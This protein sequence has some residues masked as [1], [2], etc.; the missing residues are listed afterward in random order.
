MRDGPFALERLVGQGGMGEVY[1]ATERATG[2]PVAVKLLR[3]VEPGHLGRFHR[4]AD[5]LMAIEHPAVVEYV[6]HG[7]AE[8]GRPYLAMEW[9][10]GETL[11]QRLERGA[12]SATETVA[13][14]IRVAEGLVAAHARG[15]VHCDLKPSNLLLANGRLEEAKILD[16]GIARRVW[17]QRD[18][19]A[20]SVPG[21]IAGTPAYM[22]P[23][24]ARGEPK[25]RPSTDTFALGAVLY[26]C[27]TGTRA[28]GGENALAT[29]AEICF[30][31]PPPPRSLRPEVPPDLERLVLRM[32]FK[33]ETARPKDAIEVGREL[34]RIELSPG[35]ATAPPPAI[36]RKERRASTLVL[37]A[38]LDVPADDPDE[39]QSETHERATNRQRVLLTSLL[40]PY[41]GRLE[42]LAGGVL[43]VYFSE[44][45]APTDLATRAARFALAVG[46]ALM[47]A[48]VVVCTGRVTL[49]DRPS[50]G[51]LVDG[52]LPL[53]T[54]KGPGIR[55]DAATAELLRARFVVDGDS[56]SRGAVLSAER[57]SGEAPRTVLGRVSPFVGRARELD[58]LVSLARESL[59]QRT[60]RAAVV[61]AGPGMGKSRLC[62]ET[63]R[64]LRE[65]G[66]F[67]LLVGRADVMRDGAPFGA[68][69]S[70]L[71]STAGI[72]TQC[73][74]PTRRTKL[75]DRVVRGGA[76]SPKAVPFLGEIAGVYFPDR[77]DP[78]LQG[79]RQDPRLMGD[80]MR[81]A[82][83]DWLRAELSL[84]P[85]VLVLEDLHWG[86]SPS[87]QLVDLALREFADQP[88]FV[89][90]LARPEVADRFPRLWEEHRLEQVVLQPLAKEASGAL[91]S[92]LLADAG[93]PGLVERLT[94]RA[95]GNPFFLEELVRSVEAGVTDLPDSLM[96]VVQSRLDLLGPEA[97]RLLRAASVFGESF[98]ADGVAA[99]S[100][101]GLDRVVE[102][103][104]TLQDR[105][106]LARLSGSREYQFRH[107]LVRETCYASLTS[108]D[109]T[110]GHRLAGEWLEAQGEP[111]AF[112]LAEH[113]DRGGVPEH[114]A[115]LYAR[116]ALQALQG[117]D[118]EA[119]ARRAARGV[120]LGAVGTTLAQLRL[121]QVRL[122]HDAP[123]MEALAIEAI[124]SAPPGTPTWYDAL[125]EIAVPLGE[126]L[127]PMLGWVDLAESVTPAA[128]AESSQI[129]C[130]AW[131]AGALVEVEASRAGAILERFA[132]VDLD[133]LEPW[134]ATRVSVALGVHFSTSGS[135]GDAI[136]SYGRAAEFAERCGD[137][138]GVCTAK[139]EMAAECAETGF[140]AMSLL[141]ATQL[142]EMA[143][144]HRIPQLEV[145]ACLSLGVAHHRAGQLDLAR[146]YDLAAADR[147]EQIGA[148]RMLAI[149]LFYLARVALFEGA[150][151]EAERVAR[152]STELLKEGA[153]GWRP[154]A[155][156]VLAR[157]LVGLGRTEEAQPWARVALEELQRTSW[158]P[159]LAQV[160]CAEVFWAAGDRPFAR[161]LI[162]EAAD[163]AGRRA[164]RIIDPEH[165]KG[166]L[167][168]HENAEAFRLAREWATGP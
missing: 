156:A 64:T 45:T 138:F 13:L 18:L 48:R 120:C 142:L 37:I 47:E 114:A 89:L 75:R 42:G 12:L 4:E 107:A 15:I 97:S 3:R 132:R 126:Q 54:A 20:P 57:E 61:V 82:W 94:G 139:L 32:L 58:V 125:R 111:D 145:S 100:G 40:E 108:E 53:F 17:R 148:S 165:R 112:S 92:G 78:E 106:V 35:P 79:A 43:V 168:M 14:A 131:M 104:D 99:L 67:E 129:A 68:L 46:S 119:A 27:L 135:P 19:T 130:L 160:A 159:V 84:R 166:F 102:R 6:S 109:R 134:V 93:G 69:A 38:G 163:E 10:E 88:L 90:A 81:A 136:T 164:A 152:R 11:A 116:A 115:G 34:A 150:F 147:A 55:V 21:A 158:G 71:R 72:G 39:T 28:F 70:A 140:P 86:D 105:E 25:L 23:E 96:A 143:R 5:V 7:I 44:S 146:D 65:N 144:R 63:L 56:A 118:Y 74:A 161:R 22:S 98:A 141:L 66:D 73:D 121:V 128:G 91:V 52:V 2:R 149:A 87:V 9:L 26:E 83:T 154:T 155:C 153:G 29:M 80:R 36:A 103:L 127:K 51:Q 24:Q 1:R 77:N 162:R 62:S 16:F 33:D 137:S 101:D 117:N 59:G 110:L 122:A 133:A 41:G 123:E 124:R 113:F 31:E 50:V 157:A 95:E 76:C 30:G 49:H 8:D 85:V 60:A 167:A 151:D